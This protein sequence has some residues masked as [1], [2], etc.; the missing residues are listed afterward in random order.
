MPWRPRTLD[1]DVKAYV[2][3]GD[4]LLVAGGTPVGPHH[5]GGQVRAIWMATGKDLAVADLPA[6]VSFDGM[7]AACGNVYV[8]TTD[9][10]V[11]CLGE[12]R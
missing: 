2:F 5:R 6:P 4:T 9:G 8:S 3:A 10:K 7:I 12:K 1:L 11:V